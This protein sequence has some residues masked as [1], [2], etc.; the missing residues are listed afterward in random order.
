MPLRNKKWAK[1][2]EKIHF[3]RKKHGKRRTQI[4][5][6]QTQQLKHYEK[7]FRAPEWMHHNSRIAYTRNN[8]NTKKK[9][10]TEKETELILLCERTRW[11]HWKRCLTSIFAALKVDFDD[12][13]ACANTSATLFVGY[14]LERETMTKCAL[15][16]R[17]TVQGKS[18]LRNKCNCE[19]NAHG[20]VFTHTAH[21]KRRRNDRTIISQILLLILF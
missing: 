19:R 4:K 21:G 18:E 15:V 5:E 17:C 10:V 2:A 3:M 20:H 9:L 14:G 6:E 8:N 7:W 1:R 11:S 16:R 13:G 12:F